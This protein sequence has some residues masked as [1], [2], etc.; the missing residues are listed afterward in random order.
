MSKKDKK[1]NVQSAS[2]LAALLKEKP[3]RGRPKHA[4]SREN[5]YVA[6]SKEQKQLMRQMALKLPK[7]I[8]RA[9]IPDLAISVLSVRLESLH[10]AVAD[11]SR[12][13]PEGITDLESLYLLWDLPLPIFDSE[14][15]WTSIRVSPQQALEF[16]RAQGT[17]KAAFKTTRSE[18]FALG[19][20]LLTQFI[21][22]YL[23]N[24]DN[25]TPEEV[26]RMINSN[27]L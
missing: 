10:Q 19:L 15:K 22:D 23:L 3:K 2:T 14:Q 6:L 24:A 1:K 17:L 5:V 4:V 12:A 9:D 26:R 18:T 21:E 27:Y 13:I 8:V 25:M 20:S 11:R 7:G 16:G